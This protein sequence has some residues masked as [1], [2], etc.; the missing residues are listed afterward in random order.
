MDNREPL[1]ELGPTR[2]GSDEKIPDRTENPGR[3]EH[4]DVA[5]VWYVNLLLVTREYTRYDQVVGASDQRQKTYPRS[6]VS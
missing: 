4:R 1:L 5:E 6:A 3:E 2:L